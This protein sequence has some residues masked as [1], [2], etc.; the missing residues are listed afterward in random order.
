MSRYAFIV[1]DA[2]N[3]VTVQPSLWRQAQLIAIRGLFE[4]APGCWQARGYDISNITFIAGDTGWI[5]ID[6]RTVESCAR[7]C[8]ALANVL[9]I[10]T[11]T[12]RLGSVSAR[13]P[14]SVQ[15]EVLLH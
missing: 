5:V 10:A 13:C 12:G 11:E 15:I 7:D 1:Q 4:V 3:P 8:L 9:L 6:Q 2:P 14:R